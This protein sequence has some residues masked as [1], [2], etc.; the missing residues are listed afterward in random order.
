M[1]YVDDYHLAISAFLFGIVLTSMMSTEKKEPRLLLLL[2]F[3]L[4][5]YLN[6]QNTI[7]LSHLTDRWTLRT[8]KASYLYTCIVCIGIDVY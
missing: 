1:N 5:D 8:W 6:S 4:S 2:L 7:M 3:R